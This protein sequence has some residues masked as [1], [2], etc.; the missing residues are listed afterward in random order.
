MTTDTVS[1][2]NA[3]SGY[4]LTLAGVA[5]SAHR[6][7]MILNQYEGSSGGPFFRY[8]LSKLDT[9]RC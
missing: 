2:F 3:L 7:C 1:G 5:G 9:D 4:P 6:V 8:E